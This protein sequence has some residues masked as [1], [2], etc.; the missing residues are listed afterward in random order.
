MRKHLMLLAML[1]GIMARCKTG[2]ARLVGMLPPGTP[3]A[4]KTGTLA[5]VR[6]DTG[7][8]YARQPFLLTV[9]VQGAPTS[10][11]E[12]IIAQLALLCYNAIH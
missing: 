9:L 7:I 3:V 4:H 1:L 12:H 6:G 5:Y 8:I 10:D 11:A 2:K